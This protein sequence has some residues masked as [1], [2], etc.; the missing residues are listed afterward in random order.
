MFKE[1]KITINNKKLYDKRI[2]LISDIHYNNEKDIKKLNKVLKVIKK[3]NAD[4]ICIPGDIIDKNDIS[5]KTYIINWLKE[6]SKNSIVLISLGNHDIRIK[7]EFGGYKE[8]IDKDFTSELSSI[9]NLYLLN[10]CS[11]S[12]KDI[13]FYGYTQ[14]FDYYYK[15]EYEDKNIMNKELDKYGVCKEMPN[16]Y[17]IL[18][19]HSPICFNDL[20]NKLNSYDLILCGHMHNGVVPILL[21]DIFKG[22]RGLV[23]PNR[24]LFPKLARGVVKDENVLVISSGITKIPRGA[25]LIFRLFSIFFPIGINVID[26]KDKYEINSKYFIK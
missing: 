23:A 10:N 22:N 14:S 5:D 12:F 17:K 9:D 21:D 18:L 20:K 25:A 7:D 6:L 13:Y 16:K 24:K 11:K 4:Y 3:Y 19:M 2:L 8:F 26:F 1:T 15:N